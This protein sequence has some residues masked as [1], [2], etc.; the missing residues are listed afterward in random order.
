MQC[1]TEGGECDMK[2]E[3]GG[4]ENKTKSRHKD[5]ACETT[6]E[7]GSD[8]TTSYYS[9]VSGHVVEQERCRRWWSNYGGE[10]EMRE[11][12]EMSRKGECSVWYY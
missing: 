3:S 11:E 5:S 6:T 1:E 8:F 4:G 7:S 9:R 12:G 10:R 2:T